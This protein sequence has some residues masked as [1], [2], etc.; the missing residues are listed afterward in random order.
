MTTKANESPPRQRVMPTLRI[1]N[2]ATSKKFYVEGLGFQVD[3]EHRF[4]PHFPVFMQVSRDG[5]AFFLTE[6]SGDCPVGG[7]IHLYVPDVDSWFVEFQARG[8]PV[9]EPPN[10]CLQ[11]LRSMT[12][13]DPDG[14]KLHIC[15]RLEE[16]S[17]T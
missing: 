8:V 7:L 15:T 5:L 12:V 10:E 13:L 16:W 14:N 3:W 6:H 1:T 4:E 17:R 11:G 9:Q 2:Y